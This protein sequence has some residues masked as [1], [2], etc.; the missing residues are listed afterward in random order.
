[1]GSWLALLDGRAAGGELRGGWQDR[2]S[3]WDGPSEALWPQL[4]SAGA[5]MHITHMIGALFQFWN[6]TVAAGRAI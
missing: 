2:P 3:P 1:M 5:H 4:L 6:A